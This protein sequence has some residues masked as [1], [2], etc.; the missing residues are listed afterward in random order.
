MDGF[1]EAGMEVGSVDGDV[2]ETAGVAVG[3]EAAVEK[4]I[5]GWAEG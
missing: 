1:D 5:E 3:A 4:G 2:K